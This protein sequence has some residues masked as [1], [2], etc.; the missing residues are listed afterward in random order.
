MT[1]HGPL[2]GGCDRIF[3][4]YATRENP[5]IH[6][7]AERT[8]YSTSMFTA[9]V[10]ATQATSIHPLHLHQPCLTPPLYIKSMTHRQPFPP[11]RSQTLNLHLSTHS[12]LNSTFNPPI[13]PLVF[14][15]NPHPFD[16]P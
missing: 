10:Q 13:Q 4:Y 3:S 5:Q 12:K 15:T 7:Q 14:N 2:W 6:S 8:E 16:M 11:P 9:L 1:I